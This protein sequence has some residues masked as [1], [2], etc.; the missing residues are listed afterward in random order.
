MGEAGPAG[1]LGAV[2]L[3]VS[4]GLLRFW[5]CSGRT[6][7]GSEVTQVLCSGPTGRSR[8][9]WSSRTAGNQ[10]SSGMAQQVLVVVV[11]VVLTGQRSVSG[12]GR[13]RR[14]RTS[15]TRRCQ[16]KADVRTLC[17]PQSFCILIG[18]LCLNREILVSP[19]TPA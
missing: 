11:V 17:C 15:G 5:P 7:V 19:V 10:R 2:G 6:R 9:S 1:R 14:D 3:K 16:G 13:Q 12:S 8:R 18:C 4:V